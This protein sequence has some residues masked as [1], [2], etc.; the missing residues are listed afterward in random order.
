MQLKLITSV[1]PAPAGTL[2]LA[3]VVLSADCSTKIVGAVR[4]LAEQCQPLV[5]V[6][7]VAPFIVTT[8]VQVLA[9]SVNFP[10]VAPPVVDET[11]QPDV[12]NLVPTEASPPLTAITALEPRATL[13]SAAPVGSV[14]ALQPYSPLLRMLILDAAV[15]HMSAAEAVKTMPVV[16]LRRNPIPVAPANAIPGTPVAGDAPPSPNRGTEVPE[17]VR[18]AP[19]VI[20]IAAVELV[21][22]DKPANGALVAA[23]VPLPLTPKDDPVPTSIAAAALVPLVIPENALETAAQLPSPA[24]KVVPL[25]VPVQ[26]AM[27]SADKMF[28]VGFG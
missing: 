9:P 19:V 5:A 14:V 22:P 20:I 24:I 17:K 1:A 7:P 23:I 10:A 21:P 15:N 27:M 28:S 3:V 25:Q 12:V 13:V 4:S 18:L 26:S 16:E 2:K 6:A 11:E 8:T